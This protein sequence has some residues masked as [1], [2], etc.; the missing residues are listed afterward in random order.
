MTRNRGYGQTCLLAKAAEVLCER[1][2]L[3]VVRELLLGSRRFG[4]L[5]RGIPMVSPTMLS[6]RLRELEDAGVIARRRVRGRRR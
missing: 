1:W 4:Q 2:T 5:R 6:L 3:L